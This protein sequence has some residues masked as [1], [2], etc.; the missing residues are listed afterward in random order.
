MCSGSLPAESSAK[1]LSNCSVQT[2]S[3]NS[4][5]LAEDVVGRV[6]ITGAW[7]GRELNTEYLFGL[8]ANIAQGP[9][10]VSLVGVPESY[11]IIHFVGSGDV[12][13]VAAR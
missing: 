12:A 10:A 6:D 3:I 7:E 5:L 13:A 4:T 1:H 9:S 11:D 8:F 2:R